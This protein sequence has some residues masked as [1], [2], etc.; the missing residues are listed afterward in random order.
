M[1]DWA[2]GFV[3]W[4]RIFFIFI[5]YPSP[6]VY[7]S[8][9]FSL[10][11]LECSFV[12]MLQLQ[13][14]ILINQW[15]DLPDT[16]VF[17]LRSL[18]TKSLHQVISIPLTVRLPT[19]IYWTSVKWGQSLKRGWIFMQSLFLCYIFYLSLLCRNQFPIWHYRGLFWKPLTQKPNYVECN[20]FTKAIRGGG[21]PRLEIWSHIYVASQYYITENDITWGISERKKINLSPDR[22]CFCETG[23]YKTIQAPS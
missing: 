22:V 13:P 11:W 3:Q 6:D 19:P 17:M 16:G 9:I 8:I 12:L 4:L 18:E 14:G 2:P 1:T 23:H 21:D 10:I 20:W 5:L 7:F 15:R